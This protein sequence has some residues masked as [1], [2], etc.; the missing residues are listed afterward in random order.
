MR[1]MSIGFP[2]RFHC[3]FL[4]CAHLVLQN[5]CDVRCCKNAIVLHCAN[6]ELSA[7]EVNLSNAAN[8]HCSSVPESLLVEYS[9]RATLQS[10]IIENSFLFKTYFQ[11]MYISFVVCA[12]GKILRIAIEGWW[13]FRLTNARGILI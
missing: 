5:D 6:L 8:Q 4:V 12:C 9:T 13:S 7:S 10:K 3:F 11:M 1:S 2:K